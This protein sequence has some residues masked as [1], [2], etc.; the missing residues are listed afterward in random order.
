MKKNITLVLGAGLVTGL[1]MSSITHAATIS[2]YLTT[3][4]LNTSYSGGNI[5]DGTNYAK[6]TIDDVGGTINFTVDALDSAFTG[7]GDNFGIQSFAFNITDDA[8]TLTSSDVSVPAGWTFATDSNGDGLG[9]FD[10]LLGDGGSAR[11][12]PL[13]FSIDIAGD[14]INSYFDLSNKN[15]STG[16]YFAAH[17]ADFSTGI[18]TVD[19]ESNTAQCTL[20]LVDPSCIEL[21]SINRS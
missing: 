15:N 4:N 14:D 10:V 19:G 3:A 17:I 21:R 6:V 12:E 18:G 13:T 20:V 7:T 2:Y 5:P 9:M 1:L 16:S 11:V 8:F